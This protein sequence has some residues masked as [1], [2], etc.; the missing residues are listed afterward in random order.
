MIVPPH[1]NIAIIK[2]EDGTMEQ[3]FRVWTDSVSN[4]APRIGEGSPEGVVDGLQGQF[5]MDTTGTTGAILYV[6]RDTDIG[7]DSTQGWILV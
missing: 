1:P 6:K 2:R 4:L 3:L 7:G 5:Y